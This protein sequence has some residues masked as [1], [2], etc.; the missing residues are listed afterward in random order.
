MSVHFDGICCLSYRLITRFVGYTKFGYLVSRDVHV[1]LGGANALS[2]LAC[3]RQYVRAAL[4]DQ[5]QVSSAHIH[6][7]MTYLLLYLHWIPASEG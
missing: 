3:L 2:D 7:H 1:G 4:R 5:C 6:R